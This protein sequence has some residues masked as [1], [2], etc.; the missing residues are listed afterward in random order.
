[1]GQAC[2]RG[3]ALAGG[4]GVYEGWSSSWWARLV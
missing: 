4:P 3:G 1:M 2:M